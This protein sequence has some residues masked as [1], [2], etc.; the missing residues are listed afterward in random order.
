[1]IPFPCEFNFF[2]GGTLSVGESVDSSVGAL[3]D[4]SVGLG[5]LTFGG[6]FTANN[7]RCSSVDSIVNSSDGGNVNSSVGEKVIVFGGGGGGLIEFPLKRGPGLPLP[8]SNF[9]NFLFIING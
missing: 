6:G 4:T 1:M 8:K 3:V 7:T 9:S 5:V 2:G